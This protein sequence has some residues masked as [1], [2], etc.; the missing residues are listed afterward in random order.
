MVTHTGLS[1]IKIPPRLKKRGMSIGAELTV[2][3]LQRKCQNHGKPVFF[4]NKMHN[5]KEKS[6]YFITQHTYH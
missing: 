2:I 4:M 5:E 6:K 3:G 1:T